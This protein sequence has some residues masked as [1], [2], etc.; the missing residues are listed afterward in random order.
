MKLKK[1]S[2]N[3][4]K[5]AVIDPYDFNN[6]FLLE[7][8]ILK[9]FSNK[10]KFSND[11]LLSTY[12]PTKYITTYE[13]VIP[14][15]LLEK[16]DIN[17]YIE[18]KSYEELELDETE[19]YIFKYRLISSLENEKNVIVEVIIAKQK[20]IEKFYKPI[21]KKYNYIDYIGYSG[22]LF[23][24]LYK[25]KILEPK[26]D[27]FVYFKKDVILITLYNEGEFLQTV[28]LS[29]GLKSLY[30]RFQEESSIEISDLDSYDV[31]VKLITKKGLDAD[32]YDENEEILFNGLSE[33]FSNLF[34]IIINQFTSLQRKFHLTAI[35]RI[36]ISTQNGAIPGILDFTSIYLGGIEA[37]ELKFD[38]K[39]NPNNIEIDQFLFLSML[40]AQY[41]YKNSYQTYNFT[42]NKRPPT[43]FYRKSGQFI[44][45]SI[46]SLI[47]SL[48]YP[49][50]QYIYAYIKDYENNKLQLKLNHL[51]SE[52]NILNNNFN[53]LL[54]AYK[55]DKKIVEEKKNYIANVKKIITTLYKEKK[56]YIPISSLL[57]TLSAYMKANNIYVESIDFNND[58]LKLNLFSFNDK[59]ITNFV[60]DLVEKEHFIVQTT[61]IVKN[62]SKY[63]SVVN[64]KVD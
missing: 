42:I 24:V 31:F 33:L 32:N 57:V 27:M 19:K 61:G 39:Y 54:K 10:Q 51:N 29:Q 26:K 37:N 25:D 53:R 6:I 47:I 15:N 30:K 56:G 41:A 44:S 55:N 50:Y 48:L 23:E 11:T 4:N 64:V 1:Y 9:T 45:I 18:T 2:Y 5:L 20:D 38:A 40:S 52:F 43:F 62:K 63:E 14:K 3:L 36:F 46:A 60:N 16:I 8:N 49:G 28:N 22:F 7:N 21:I 17:D 58:V 13:F 12:I 59:Y 34:M 35:D